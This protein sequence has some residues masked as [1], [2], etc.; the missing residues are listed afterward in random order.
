VKSLLLFSVVLLHTG[1][2]RSTL[3][4]SKLPGDG[5]EEA[6]KVRAKEGRDRLL[7]RFWGL[8]RAL[9]GPRATK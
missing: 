8:E 3:Y 7:H 9:A 4:C 2:C 5:V 1:L 6:I